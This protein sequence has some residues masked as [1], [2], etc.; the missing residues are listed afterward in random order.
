MALTGTV[1]LHE[2]VKDMDNPVTHNVVRPDGTEETI[3]TH[4]MIELEGEVIE[5]AYV[6][7][8]MAAIHLD[9]NDRI[10]E[11]VDDDGNIIGDITSETPRG[12]TKNG[13]K[14]K[15][16]LHT[17]KIN[18]YLIFVLLATVC[19]VMP[20]RK[21]NKI[22][23]SNV[24]KGF[25]IN[26]NPVFKFIFEQL[27]LNKKLSI[28][29][30][31]FLIGP[32]INSGG[33]L[34][35]SNYGV[36]LLTTNNLKLIQKRSI[37]LIKLNEKRKILEQNILDEIDYEKINKQNQKVIIYYDAN[38]NEGL[39]GIIAAR[40]KDYFNKPSIVITK[41]NNT[42]KASARSTSNYNI[43]NL[44][45]SLIDNKIIEKGGGHNM[46][47]GFTIKKS[48]LN[49]LNKF[50]QKD[51]NNKIIDADL[52]Y[53]YD[54]EISSSLINK[55]FID[56]INKLGPFGNHNFMPI[57]MIRNVKIIKSSI[58]NKKHISAIVKPNTGSSFKS[59]CFNSVNTQIGNY[60]L[61]YKKHIDIIGEI[62]ENIWNNKKSIQLN[63]KDLIL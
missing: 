3:T 16:R 51:Y 38:I 13:Y 8:K 36:E 18:N 32:I 11:E 40:L 49:S 52:S 17:I 61:S 4:P 59:I 47:A 5:N 41:S 31:G 22:I 6:I 42:L 46:A 50:I 20:L 29:D 24:I 54:S 27:S 63:I 2:W 58:L 39:I 15:Y 26:D 25:K 33:R 37:E 12:E 14:R 45:K 57:F 28:D 34:G 21:I 23:A 1:K 19:D 10:L 60:L 56:E 35:L 53:K 44:I 30:L 62:N 55:K 9:D 48:K 7:I 43:G